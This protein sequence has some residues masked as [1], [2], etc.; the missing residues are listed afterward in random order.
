MEN[1]RI[2][3]Q[4]LNLGDKLIILKSIRKYQERKQLKEYLIYE[5]NLNIWNF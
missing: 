5:K 4:F 2:S 1:T 3:K